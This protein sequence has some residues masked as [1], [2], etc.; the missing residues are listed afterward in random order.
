MLDV[1]EDIAVFDVYKP[2]Y[3][4]ESLETLLFT[5]LRLWEGIFSIG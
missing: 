5:G 4:V 2:L 3:I 1:T